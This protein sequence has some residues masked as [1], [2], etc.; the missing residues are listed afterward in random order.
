MS[1]RLR[2]KKLA[3]MLWQN[4]LGSQ[5][6]SG[7]G[8]PPTPVKPKKNT[9]GSPLMPKQLAPPH[10]DVGLHLPMLQS[11][12]PMVLMMDTAAVSLLA[13]P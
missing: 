3:R 13:A 1:G 8:A 9:L 6:K 10:H 2:S 4:G 5:S 11:S 7:M 12:A